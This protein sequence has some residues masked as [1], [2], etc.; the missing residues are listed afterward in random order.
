MT[1]STKKRST[2]EE[3]RTPACPAYR[4]QIPGHQGP[5]RRGLAGER[6]EAPIVLLQMPLQSKSLQRAPVGPQRRGHQHAGPCLHIAPLELQQGL[7]VFQ[8]PL[9]GASPLGHAP[10]LQF[11]AGGPIHQNGQG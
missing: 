1:L 10:L 3:S 8:G 7:R 11:G 5:A 4:S 6:G 9:L 2:P